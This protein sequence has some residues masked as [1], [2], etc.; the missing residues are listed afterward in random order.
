VPPDAHPAARQLL[1]A[2]QLPGAAD[3][4]S[5]LNVLYD[6]AR[7]LGSGAVGIAA[8]GAYGRARAALGRLIGQG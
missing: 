1:R 3:P 8:R 7:G 5:A 4:R 6:L 2:A